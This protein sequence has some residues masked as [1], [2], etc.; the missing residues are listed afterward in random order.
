MEGDAHQ[1]WHDVPLS[2]A[3]GTKRDQSRCMHAPLWPPQRSSDQ[4]GL[5]MTRQMGAKNSNFC[6]R[7]M[8]FHS[9]LSRGCAMLLPMPSAS[10]PVMRAG[11]IGVGARRDEGRGGAWVASRGSGSPR[12]S[13]AQLNRQ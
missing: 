11:G 2:S 7:V 3:L 13:L 5:T 4:Q 6:S 10:R 9:S 12:C 1:S 8:P